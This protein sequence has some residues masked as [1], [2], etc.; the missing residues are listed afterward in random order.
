MCRFYHVKNKRFHFGNANLILTPVSLVI[1]ILLDSLAMSERH[2]SCS[3]I[4]KFSPV[5]L[6]AF[7][8]VISQYVGLFTKTFFY[9]LLAPFNYQRMS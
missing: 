5:L 6:Y 7:F 8:V 1:F 2:P 3:M 4:E 9:V